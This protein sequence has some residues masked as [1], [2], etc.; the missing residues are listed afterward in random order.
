MRA[1]STVLRLRITK[2]GRNKK[3][4]KKERKAIVSV[5]VD[6]KTRDGS[7]AR[8]RG[9]GRPVDDFNIGIR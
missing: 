5:N 8:K 2:R 6:K 1:H 4:R 7:Q 9:T 3:K